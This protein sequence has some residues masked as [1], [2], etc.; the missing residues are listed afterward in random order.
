MNRWSS[1]AVAVLLAAA[2]AKA[3]IT[4]A[5]ELV[6]DDALG[7]ICIKDLNQLSRRVE[8]LAKKLNAR[9]HVS[10][11]ELIHKEFGIRQG[12]NENGS[13]VFVV[14]KEKKGKTTL[15]PIV[16]V[17]VTDY[18]KILG[19]LG[20]KQRN[21]GISEGEIGVPTGL[22]A[23]VGGEGQGETAKNKSRVLVARKGGFALLASPRDRESLEQVL[24]SRTSVRA[25]VRPA[26]DWLTRQEIC[27]VCTHHSVKAGLAMLLAGPGGGVGSSTQGQYAKLKATYA[28]AEK[29][30]KFIAFGARIGNAGNP[31]LL[32]RVY[33][34]PDGSFA[35]WIAKAEPL[36]GKVLERFPGP[37]HYLV[38]V[39]RLSPQ[40]SFEGAA[41]LLWAELIPQKA[42]EKLTRATARLLQ[43]ISEV[44]LLVYEPKARGKPAADSPDNRRPSG[45]V[46]L[47]LALLA[48]V[49]DAAAFSEG[50]A[51]LFQQAHQAAKEAGKN[52]GELKLA[53]VQVA[54]KR[55][56]V[57]SLSK[58]KKDKSAAE[59]AEQDRKSSEGQLRAILNG[60]LR[61]L[62]TQLDPHT[63][64]TG[65]PSDGDQAKSF[66]KTFAIPPRRSLKADAPLQRTAALLPKRLQ[67]AA[68]L[69]V[70][71]LGVPA[72]LL[73]AGVPPGVPESPP[74]GF[75]LRTMPA[76]VEAQFVI[77]FEALQAVV[78]AA[79]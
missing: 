59:E 12:L 9:E 35:K 45:R 62:L 79:K 43:R 61:I 6:P 70:R 76:G 30:V 71:S 27:G 50:V 57:I 72:A 33:F 64:L 24:K 1:V 55:T 60:Q 14:M 68:Y 40:T 54:G 25:S 65:G 2:P 15:R 16:A 21:K 73:G 69:S 66:V 20:V 4:K 11:L 34:D 10:L 63:V 18:R 19:Q 41:S 22:L 74:L 32:T 13:A 78:N 49:D 58:T 8:D 53:R 47:E 42:A 17:P 38:G 7:F 52:T 37:L 67:V 26:Q 36:Q 3:Q 48:K 77:P 29:N 75:A 51:S 5:L 28:D 56:L 39:A 46:H 23:G 44:G 31:R